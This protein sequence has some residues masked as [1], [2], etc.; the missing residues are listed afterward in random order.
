MRLIRSIVLGLLAGI[1]FA[2]LGFAGTWA[3]GKFSVK[4]PLFYQVH[5]GLSV[6]VG[7]AVGI[8]TAFAVYE[9]DV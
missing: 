3:E 7:I 6:I 1:A 9:N 5:Q 8:G 4:T 2:L